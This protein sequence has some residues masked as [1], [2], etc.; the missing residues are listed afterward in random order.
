MMTTTSQ[1]SLMTK[2]PSNQLRNR[3]NYQSNQKGRAENLSQESYQVT[4]RRTLKRMTPRRWCQRNPSSK[5]LSQV[6]RIVRKFI[7]DY[8][9]FAKTT[10]SSKSSLKLI[11]MIREFTCQEIFLCPKTLTI[12]F[13]TTKSLVSN[14]FTNSGTA[15]RVEFWVTIWVWGRRFKWQPISRDSS[16]QK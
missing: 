4:K 9:D 6:R 1:I 15:A 5:L 12:A 13:L 10:R 16:M 14:G 11:R 2:S 7:P 8:P 3:K